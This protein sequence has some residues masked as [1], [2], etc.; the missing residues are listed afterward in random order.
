MRFKKYSN[1]MLTETL[2]NLKKNVVSNLKCEKC[3]SPMK[4]RSGDKLILP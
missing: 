3:N 4:I 1:E 2:D